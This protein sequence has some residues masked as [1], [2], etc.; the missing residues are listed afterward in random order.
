MKFTSLKFSW[1]SQP[2]KTPQSDFVGGAQG[3]PWIGGF[4]ATLH[5]GTIADRLATLFE[6]ISHWCVDST[7]AIRISIKSDQHV[8]RVSI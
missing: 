6:S 2:Y 8:S 1:G 5:L 4:A 7:S 3:P